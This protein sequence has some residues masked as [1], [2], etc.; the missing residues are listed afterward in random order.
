M[1]YRILSD[2]VRFQEEFLTGLKKR[3]LDQKF[4]Y[5]DEN[6][7]TYYKAIK[8]S[9]SY[10]GDERP[11]KDDLASFLQTHTS[12]GRRT[13]F[14]SIGC[15]D[16][17][18]ERYVM[19]K[20][21]ADGDYTYIAVD[22]SHAMLKLSEETLKGV[23]FEVKLVL[24]DFMTSRFTRE[25]DALTEEYDERIFLFYDNTIGNL[26]QTAAVDSFYNM[27]KHNELLIVEA[28]LRTGI[29]KSD[30]LKRF[31]KYLSWLENETL[32]NYLMWPLTRIGITKEHGKIMLESFDAAPTGAFGV[33]FYFQ[34]LENVKATY[35]RETL[36]F[37][38]PERIRLLDVHI[39]DPER[40]VDFFVDRDF[41]LRDKAIRSH[42][43]LFVFKK[44]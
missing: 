1:E 5:F 7:T 39:Y 42:R 18:I 8:S 3:V 12:K 41:L 13:A 16:S 30:D 6:A 37:M 20:L 36:H 32:M 19:E 9:L 38:K 11:T 40:F 17:S 24:G 33:R 10:T 31:K 35:R 28:S 23:N 4:L 21:N 2:S 34:M 14:I 25:L 27:L 29:S 26:S 22:S 15:G 43:A 44:Q